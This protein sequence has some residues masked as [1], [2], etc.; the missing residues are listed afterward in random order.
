MKYAWYREKEPVH[1]FN[2][3]FF[4]RDGKVGVVARHLVRAAETKLEANG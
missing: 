3:D 4:R 1:P 2:F